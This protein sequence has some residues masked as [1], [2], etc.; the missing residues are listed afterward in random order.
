MAQVSRLPISLLSR[1]GYS[2]LLVVPILGPLAYL[3]ITQAPAPTPEVLRND[4][5]R[6]EYTHMWL[7]MGPIYKAILKERSDRVKDK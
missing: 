5:P 7:S 2:C 1:F 3:W 6:G 4:Q